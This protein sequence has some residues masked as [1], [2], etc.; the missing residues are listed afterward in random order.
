MRALTDCFLYLKLSS[1]ILFNFSI[2]N[3]TNNINCKIYEQQ[4]T[5]YFIFEI[6]LGGKQV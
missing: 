6:K 4:Y 5:N 3:I 1:M 2:V